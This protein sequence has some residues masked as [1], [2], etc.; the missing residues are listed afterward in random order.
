[1][2]LYWSIDWLVALHSAVDKKKPYGV[3]CLS[4]LTDM[5]E[6]E[7]SRLSLKSESNGVEENIFW[8][9]GAELRILEVLDE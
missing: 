3:D 1:M 9:W 2:Q 5:I 6:M 8:L 7:Y 4:R